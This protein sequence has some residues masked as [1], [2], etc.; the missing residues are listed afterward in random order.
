MK[1]MESLCWIL[2]II[3]LYNGI[4]TNFLLNMLKLGNKM[5]NKQ[6]FVMF[7]G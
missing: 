7:K 4:D 1:V 5:N 3:H 6:A 2:S